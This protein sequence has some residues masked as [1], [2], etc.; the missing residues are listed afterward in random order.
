MLPAQPF[1]IFPNSMYYG[2][3]SMKIYFQSATSQTLLFDTNN[4]VN[5]FVNFK[6]NL[7]INQ[8]KMSA[9]FIRK[10]DCALTHFFDPLS[11]A[12]VSTCPGQ[13]GPNSTTKYCEPCHA[14]CATCVGSGIDKCSTC[15]NATINKFRQLRNS[16][17]ISPCDCQVQ[18][19]QLPD[20]SS[21]CK[22]CS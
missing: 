20:G 10:I 19:F 14:T 6:G 22:K 21:I 9:F 3:E 2:I 5:F 17:S 8:V 15:N 1:Y 7:N 18:Y 12:C 11:Y 4:F 13:T 16:L